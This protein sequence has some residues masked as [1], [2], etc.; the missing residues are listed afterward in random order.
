M[1]SGRNNEAMSTVGRWTGH[2]AR[3]LRLALRLSV[4]AFAEHLGIAAR[5][6]SKWEKAGQSTTPWPDSQAILDTTLGH[7]PDA[8]K[9]RFALLI[10]GE[11]VLDHTDCRSASTGCTRSWRNRSPDLESR[12]EQLDAL[13]EWSAARQKLALAY[14]NAGDLTKSRQYIDVALAD[15]RN[16]SPLRQ[17]RLDT[18][19]AHILLHDR[20]TVHSAITTLNHAKTQALHYG[21]THQLQAIGRIGGLLER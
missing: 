14:L 18:A 2:E 11:T 9:A 15:R 21:L 5:T 6:I 8:A 1:Q 3:A 7:A 19:H 10:T 12:F 20:D 13:E 4:R 17:V 16:G